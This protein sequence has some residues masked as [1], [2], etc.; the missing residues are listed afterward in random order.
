[1]IYM[2]CVFEGMICMICV[3]EGRHIRGQNDIDLHRQP[4]RRS[5]Y[6]TR[7]SRTTCTVFVAYICWLGSVLHRSRATHHNDK[8]LVGR[9]SRVVTK[10]VGAVSQLSDFSRQVGWRNQLMPSRFT[11]L[12]QAS[13]AS[14]NSPQGQAFKEEKNHPPLNNHSS[15]Y[16]NQICWIVETFGRRLAI[17]PTNN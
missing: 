1:M 17:S 13:E 14:Q 3:F 11:D 7:T 16:G 4:V 2:I 8:Q 6:R 5:C 10:S 9:I 15:K 12:S